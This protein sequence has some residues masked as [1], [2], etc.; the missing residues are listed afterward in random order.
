MRAV[1]FVTS[2]LLVASPAAGLAEG[3]RP[4]IRAGVRAARTAGLE[5]A[6]RRLLGRALA[7]AVRMAP[8][9][10]RRDLGELLRDPALRVTREGGVAKLVG[11]AYAASLSEGKLRLE[12]RRL[13]WSP[14]RQWGGSGFLVSGPFRYKQ[15]GVLATDTSTG[16]EVPLTYAV[17]GRLE[18]D[19]RDPRRVIVVDPTVEPVDAPHTYRYKPG[20]GA[21]K[22]L[23]GAV[24]KEVARLYPDA[25]K[26][27]IWRDRDTAGYGAATG[28]GRQKTM[29]YDLALFR[30]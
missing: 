20:S 17:Y 28:R 1:A 8:R 25:A 12:S 22:Q 5:R 3:D 11:S 30:R 7:A 14:Q 2:L 19:Y 13:E 23:L 21:M 15:P 18:Q 16:R 29:D 4:A 26:M 27:I 9:A 6:E 10:D 24:G